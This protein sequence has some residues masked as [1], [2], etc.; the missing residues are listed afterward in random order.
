[1][2]IL[3]EVQSKAVFY[4]HVGIHYQHWTL[5]PLVAGIVDLWWAAEHKPAFIAVAIGCTVIGAIMSLFGTF[6][7]LRQWAFRAK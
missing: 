5:P 4:T 2:V 1:M 6:R 3:P 7:W